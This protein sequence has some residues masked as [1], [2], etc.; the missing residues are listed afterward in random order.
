M[1]V[2]R[3]QVQ[4]LLRFE[5]EAIC[6]D[7]TDGDEATAKNGGTFEEV[8]IIIMYFILNSCFSALMLLVG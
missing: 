7:S 8:I 3:Y 6:S 1:A 5:I 4:I 2:C